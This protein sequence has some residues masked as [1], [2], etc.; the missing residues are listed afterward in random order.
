[1]SVRQKLIECC[2]TTIIVLALAATGAAA[3]KFSESPALAD[4]VK[5]GGLPPV[6]QRLPEHPRVVEVDTI[7]RYGGDLRISM[8]KAKDTRMMTVYGYA[9]LVGYEQSYSLVPDILESFD[10][11]DARTFTLHLR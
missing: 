2:L 7:G 10:I 1:M 4:L 11:E 3:G 5:A 8:A 6:A 9:R